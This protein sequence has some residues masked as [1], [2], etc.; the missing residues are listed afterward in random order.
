MQNA[1]LK[2]FI[3]TKTILIDIFRLKTFSYT[4]QT[5]NFFIWFL[6]MSYQILGKKLKTLKLISINHYKEV[7]GHTGIIWE[8]YVISYA[9]T[10]KCVLAL[11]SKTE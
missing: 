9:E 11:Y 4:I 5:L 8:T 2:R 10:L 3:S 7:I 1:L 6:A